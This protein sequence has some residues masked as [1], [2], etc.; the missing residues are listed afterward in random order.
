M[1]LCERSEYCIDMCVYFTKSYV[2]NKKIS[3]HINKKLYAHINQ[4]HPLIREGV[5]IAE[6]IH[7]FVYTNIF[8]DQIAPFGRS[9]NFGSLYYESISSPSLLWKMYLDTQNCDQCF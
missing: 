4:F 8:V 9:R 1:F 3:E 5:L 7:F 6:K 2:S